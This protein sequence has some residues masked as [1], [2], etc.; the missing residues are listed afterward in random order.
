MKHRDIQPA[1]EKAVLTSFSKHLEQKGVKMD[2]VSQPDP[3][4]AIVNFNGQLNWVEITDAFQSPDWARSITT[5]VAEDKTHI[6]YQRGLI[7][8][9]DAEACKKVQEV[10]LKKYQ[11]QTINSIYQ[12]N[13]AGIL[14]VGAY[15]PLTSP[16]EIIELASH[17]ISEA[18]SEYE[19]IFSSIYL[20]TNS[21]S[22]HSFSLLYTSETA[23]N[24]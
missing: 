15:T 2:I 13:G 17:L 12:N 19:P 21:E 16:Q 23:A 11:K 8:E 1:H 9:P 18:I 24:A 4:D 3:P 10:V 14:L 6:P 22:G 7:H 5:Y 20:Y